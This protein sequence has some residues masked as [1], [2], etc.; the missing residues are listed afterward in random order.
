MAQTLL[1]LAELITNA[2]HQIDAACK[3]RNATFPALDDPFD[4]IS[5][6]IRADPQVAQAAAV[7]TAAA[8][9]FIATTWMPGAQVV[10]KALEVCS[11][12]WM[13]PTE[14][15]ALRT[16]VPRIVGYSRCNCDKCRRI[17]QGCRCSGKGLPIFDRPM[18]S[19]VGGTC[20]RNYQWPS[21]LT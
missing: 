10:Q 21:N 19:P 2:A 8:E 1:A 14:L 20:H 11:R 16:S 15:N 18:N 17:S 3:Q 6:E 7:A 4:P 13:F 5:E 9:Q 12:L